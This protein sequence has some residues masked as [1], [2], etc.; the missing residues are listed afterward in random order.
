MERSGGAE[1]AGWAGRAGESGEVNRRRRRAE[2]PWENIGSKQSGLV[3]ASVPVG[4]K[5]LLHSSI[6][7][8]LAL[9]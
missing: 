4:R 2:C 1:R 5:H 9:G 8:L 6:F 3:D 7:F